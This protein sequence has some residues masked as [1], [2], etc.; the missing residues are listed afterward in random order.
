MTPIGSLFVVWLMSG[1]SGYRAPLL[2]QTR[3][4]LGDREHLAL[5][6]RLGE[7][8][9]HPIDGAARLPGDEPQP[10]P[11]VVE[12]ELAPAGLA[13]LVRVVE[14]RRVLPGHALDAVVLAGE[15]LGD[16]EPVGLV[17]LALLVADRVDARLGARVG[18]A[19]RAQRREV[20]G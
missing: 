10:A 17:L 3:E 1:R 14:D 7:R 11:V 2:L 20:E 15:A 18:G 19:A 4:R 13:H 6:E 5:V 12:L 9:R 8:V 16:H